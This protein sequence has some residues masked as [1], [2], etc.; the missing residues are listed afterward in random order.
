[1]TK[2]LDKRI[3]GLRL[4]RE[5][6]RFRDNDQLARWVEGLEGV[7]VKNIGASRDGQAMFGLKVGRGEKHVS[8]IAGSHADEPI[9]PLTAQLLPLVLRDSFSD[10]LDAYTFYIVPQMNPD[11]A[12]NNRAWFADPPDFAQYVMSA[13]R[14]TPGDDIEFCFG[15]DGRPENLAAMAFLREG[16]PLAA[17]FSL[18]GMGFA[19]G[20]WFLVCKE[21]ADRAAPYMDVLEGFV[22][23]MQFPLHDIER[24][25]EKGFNRIRKGFCTTPTS[26]A[27]REFFEAQN[28]NAMA[29]KFLPSS[30]EFVQSLGGD[31]MCVVTE[32]P[33]FG[34]GKR[35][36]SLDESMSSKF[37]DELI[38]IRAMDSAKRDDALLDLS[39]R[40][41]VGPVSVQF[42]V[43]SQI[44]AI[45]YALDFLS[46]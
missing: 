13:I 28:D 29:E 23:R 4:N 34:I 12:D 38:E 30:M 6:I 45:I 46:T 41:E 24:N 42:Q 8:I 20:A 21:W 35:G 44:A 18:H 31:P 27:M 26:V 39:F 43:R 25:G 33:L 16:A 10:L 9:G 14:E 15:D 11:G 37:R 19:E 40:Y 7:E 1:M 5:Y 32:M 2:A 22:R 17:H 36:T 3:D